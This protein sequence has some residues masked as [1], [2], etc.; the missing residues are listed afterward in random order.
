MNVGALDLG[1]NSFSLLVGRARGRRIEKRA[2]QKVSLRIGDVVARHGALPEPAFENALAVARDL[3]D[4]AREEGAICLAAV[5]T[6]ALRDAQNGAEFVRAAAERFGLTVEL[7]SGDEEAR[8]AYSGALSALDGARER[9]LVLDLGGGSAEVAVGDG[10]ECLA[11]ESLPLGFLRVGRE[12]ELASPLNA[13]DVARIAAYVRN[14]AEPALGR[15]SALEPRAFV[16]SGGTARTLGRVATTLGVPSLG[17]AGLRR[18]ASHLSG[19]DPSHLAVLGVEA[20]RSQVFGVAIVV[21]ATLVELMA[22]PSVRV[23]PG[24]LREGI[25]LRETKNRRLGAARAATR[26]WA[27]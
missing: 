13:A 25:V 21:L 27:A 20:S 23:S 6:S 26:T 15:V 19:R 11:V 3:A 7:V 18:L 9:A 5:G 1:S 2:T 24:G 17:S 16:L 22:A 10:D 12:L 8:L 14:V 4:K